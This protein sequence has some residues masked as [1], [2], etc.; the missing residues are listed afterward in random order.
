MRLDRLRE[1]LSYSCRDLK[2]WV[3]SMA[4]LMSW[5]MAMYSG[6]QSSVRVVKPSRNW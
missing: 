2:D 4:E 3:I 6:R 5:K 1:K